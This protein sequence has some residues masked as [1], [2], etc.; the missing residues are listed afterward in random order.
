MSKSTPV[1]KELEDSIIGLKNRLENLN[2]TDEIDKV[3]YEETEK[4]L[5]A[6]REILEYVDTYKWVKH[7]KVIEKVK[8][9]RNCR[10]DYSLI[11]DE[12]DMTA[13]ALKS[14]MYRV[15]TNLSLKIGENTIKTILTGGESINIGLSVFRVLTGSLPLEDILLKETFESLPNK[16]YT[17]FSLKDC[18]EEIQYLYTYS[19]VGREFEEM[20][21]DQNKLAFIRYILESETEKYKVEQRNLLAVLRGKFKTIDEYIDY[22]MQKEDFEL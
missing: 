12:L 17:T 19:K 18:I 9:V 11:R 6:L 5:N 21:L 15:N 2:S 20:D 14:F 16:K 1:L 4:K 8:F 3:E 13:D 10:Y 22:I 7:K